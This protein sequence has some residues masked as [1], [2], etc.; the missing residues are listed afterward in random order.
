MYLSRFIGS[1]VSLWFIVLR[2]WLGKLFICLD[3]VV[4]YVK[5]LIIYILM[6]F[7]GDFS[8]LGEKCGCVMYG[9]GIKNIFG[10]WWFLLC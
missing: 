8:E 3:C 5:M 7:Y 6:F 1:C 9:N 2:Y 4:K 10:I